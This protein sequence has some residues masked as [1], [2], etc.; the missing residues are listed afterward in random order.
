[1][2]LMVVFEESR[3]NWTGF[4]E[5][6]EFLFPIAGVPAKKSLEKGF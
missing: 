1:M 4:P 5:E 3:L 2:V 6:P